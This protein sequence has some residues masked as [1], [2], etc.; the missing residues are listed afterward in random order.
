[1]GGREANHEQGLALTVYQRPLQGVKEE[2]GC[3]LH[4]T[5]G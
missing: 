4:T 2:G 1:V 5:W 3:R